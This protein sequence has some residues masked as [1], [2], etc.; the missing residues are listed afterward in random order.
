[1]PSIKVTESCEDLGISSKLLMRARGVLQEGIENKI[2]MG[3][4][5]QVGRSE[6]VL[7]PRFLGRRGLELD[8]PKVEADT[9]FLA[10][11]V[12][13][14]VT[15]TAVMLLVEQGK[16]HLDDSVSTLVPEFS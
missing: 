4:A 11:S 7:S 15:A 5:F 10:A 6:R 16:L 2:I 8:S 1:M 14:P 13:K 9:I 12:T 3:A